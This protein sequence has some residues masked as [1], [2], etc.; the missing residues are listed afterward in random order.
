[1]DGQAPVVACS[2]KIDSVLWGALWGM[3][4]IRL[5]GRLEV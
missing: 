5:R 3:P 1:M 2:E 4:W